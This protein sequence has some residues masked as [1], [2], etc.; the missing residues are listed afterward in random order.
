MAEAM[1]STLV[2]GWTAV[3]DPDEVVAVLSAVPGGEYPVCIF[4][5]RLIS[6]DNL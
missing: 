3:T 5:L 6:A 2:G 4:S 1:A